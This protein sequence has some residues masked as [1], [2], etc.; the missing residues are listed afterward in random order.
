MKRLSGYAVIFIVLSS[1]LVFDGCKRGE[2]DPF[3]SIRSRKAR[4]TGD[5][6]IQTMERNVTQLLN[7]G[8]TAKINF[9]V[10][11]DKIAEIVDSVNTSHD[12]SVTTNG[13]IKED[14]YRFD[15]N[16]K[17][18]YLFHYEM[19][20]L[21]TKMDEATNITTYNKMVYTYVERAAGSWNFLSS[22]EKHGVNK[23]KDKERLCLI[24][25]SNNITQ[26]TVLTYWQVDENGVTLPGNTFNT[27]VTSV[28]RKYSNGEFAQTWVLRELR[29]KKI[30][31]ERDIDDVVQTATIS[32]GVSTGDSYSEKGFET[33]T[34]KPRL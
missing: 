20:K 11:D 8:T 5:W 18:E 21:W 25:E 28:E 1:I 34:L 15:K 31:M 4:V 23:Y 13:I 14:F 29:S 12:T 32:N 22:V 24:F 2:D 26:T 10:T 17:M 30:V 16:S 3:F 7:D 33:V 27:F 9:K 19:S 6:A